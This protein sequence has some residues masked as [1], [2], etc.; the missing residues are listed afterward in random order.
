MD[1][2]LLVKG[3]SNKS[4]WGFPKGKINKDEKEIDCAARE[5]QPTISNSISKHQPLWDFRF[6][7]K[8]LLI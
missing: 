8:H 2:V 1:K 6:M 5:V 4:S 3:W 7:K